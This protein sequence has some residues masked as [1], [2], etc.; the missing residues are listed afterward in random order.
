MALVPHVQSSK[1]HT[2]SD[3]EIS[4]LSCYFGF[5]QARP[6]IGHTDEQSTAR[7]CAL[8]IYF[9]G[10]ARNDWNDFVPDLWCKYPAVI[11][12]S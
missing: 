3:V 8:V 11:R 1:A 2:F 12:V 5:L 10:T 7:E 9:R 4:T 6:E